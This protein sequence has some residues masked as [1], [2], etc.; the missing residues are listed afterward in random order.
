MYWLLGVAAVGGVL[1]WLSSEENN[2][3]N[4][5][6]AKSDRLAKETQS[7]Q[8]QLK[9]LRAN[10]ALAKDYY[11]H[12]EL[13]HA[14]VQT[15]DACHKLYEDHK[16]LFKM[17]ANR[18]KLLGEQI[19]KLKQQ[20]DLAT[21]TEKQAIREQ[22]T[23]TR[24]FLAQAKSQRQA[25]FNEKSRLLEQLRTI[26]QQTRDLKIYIGQHCGQKG[27]DWYARIEQRKTM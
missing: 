21:G 27:R 26:N 25:L 24:D 13:H 2:A 22:L 10:R 4:D 8:Q 19:G 1:A 20:R 15:A 7:R 11:Q 9:T 5:Y 14:S 18:E 3:R 17:I 23:Q 16:K 6:Y 12:I